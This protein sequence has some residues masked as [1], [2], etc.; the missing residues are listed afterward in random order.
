MGVKHIF[1][2]LFSGWLFSLLFLIV[3]FSI[4][5]NTQRTHEPLWIHSPIDAERQAA[6][7]ALRSGALNKMCE[8]SPLRFV[9]RL[10]EPRN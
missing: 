10:I 3:I 7:L 8:C 2:D 4:E 5:F 9:R 1:P 6:S